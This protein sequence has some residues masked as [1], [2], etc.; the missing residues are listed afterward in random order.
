MRIPYFVENPE[1]NPALPYPFPPNSALIL[2]AM[3]N[4][5]IKGTDSAELASLT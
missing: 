2:D 5:R 3:K 4:R 1:E